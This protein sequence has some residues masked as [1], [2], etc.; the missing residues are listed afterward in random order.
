MP[1]PLPTIEVGSQPSPRVGLLTAA[2]GPMDLGDVHVTTAGAQFESEAC[3]DDRL[4]PTACRDVPYDAFVYDNREALRTV[5]A[6]NV[7]AS[8]I[9]TPV[10]TTLAEAHARVN[11]RLVLGEQTAVEKG[12]WGGNGGNVVGIFEQMQAAS[13]VTAVPGTAG[14]IESLSLLEQTAAGLYDGRINIHARPR[15]A[16]YFANR[17]L[18]YT[19]ARRTG[20][21]A[22]LSYSHFGSEFVF[23]AGYAG[24]SPTGTAPDATTE[25]V[26]ATGRILMWRS[27]VT[28][29]GEGLPHVDPL[30]NRTTNQRAIFA[31]RTYAVAVEC[32]AAAVTVTR[33]AAT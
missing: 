25:T 22:D 19:G 16:A 28:S 9:C 18:I 6:F 15:M 2:V 29:P 5:Y 21:K 23:G 32:F 31:V 24:S 8:E 3:T 27:G 1:L 33:G 7:Y 30:L 13:L 17:G 12:L 26:Y 10:G 4:Y 20:E 14:P 11:R